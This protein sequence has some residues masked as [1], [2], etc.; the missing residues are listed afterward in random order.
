MPDCSGVL[1]PGGNFPSRQFYPQ[2]AVI[3]RVE[4][5]P[6]NLGR[7]IPIELGLVGDVAATI[8]ALAPLLDESGDPSHLERA[9]G[10]YRKARKSLDDLA[11]GVAGDLPVHP[12]HVARGVSDLAADDA[13]VTCDVGLPTVWAA[14]YLKMNGRRRLLGSF[15]HGSIA[16][17]MAQAIGAQA[18]NPGRQVVSLSGDGGFAMLMGD[19]I[20]LTQLKLPI[21]VIV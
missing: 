1:I 3:D 20:S 10:H 2:A 15:V 14:R 21:K 18:A 9:L 8:D 5:R 16:N 11:R 13:I 12:Q 7:K 19:L 6:E 4:I 17:A